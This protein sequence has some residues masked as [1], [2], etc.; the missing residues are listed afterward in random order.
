MP[1]HTPV[2]LAAGFLCPGPARY[3]PQVEWRDSRNVDALRD[4]L[5][6]RDLLFCA[7]GVVLTIIA[8]NRRKIATKFRSMKARLKRLW[9]M[10]SEDR[11]DG[12]R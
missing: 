6:L 3:S 8:T 11:H 12:G 4:L 9:D 5:T 1:S 2:W 7:I 10:T